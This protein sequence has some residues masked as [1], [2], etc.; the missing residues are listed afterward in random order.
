MNLSIGGR[1]GATLR[2]LAFGH[3]RAKILAI[4]GLGAAVAVIAGIGMLI[5]ARVLGPALL[6]SELDQ[7]RGQLQS[8]RDE[9]ARV[10][11]ALTRDLDALALRLGKL[12]AE[13]TRLNAL[14]ERL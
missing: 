9:L 13:A 6:S 8:Q 5:G 2:V 14:G 4:C 3:G 12:Q 11:Q 10:N 1:P 7:A